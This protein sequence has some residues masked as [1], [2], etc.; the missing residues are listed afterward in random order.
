MS[1]LSSM[2]DRKNAIKLSR[3]ASQ[4][5]NAAVLEH[6]E[7]STST[8][9]TCEMLD[10]VYHS[11]SRHEME[12]N[13]DLQDIDLANPHVLLYLAKQTAYHHAFWPHTAKRFTAF[14]NILRKDNSVKKSLE[15]G[16]LLNMLEELLAYNV[17][18]MENPLNNVPG[19]KQELKN[20]KQVISI[21]EGASHA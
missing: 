10:K 8:G 9:Y 20:I 7:L 13:A 11:E 2:F 1:Q 4:Y 3:F 6:N 5:Y 14:K 16:K 12:V 21:V 17:K 15:D 18:E 19:K